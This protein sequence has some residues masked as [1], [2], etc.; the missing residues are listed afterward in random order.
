MFDEI[1]RH[2]R[3]LLVLSAKG[4]TGGHKRFVTG[5]QLMTIQSMYLFM[6]AVV[7][8]LQV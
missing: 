6:L 4:T 3:Y 8:D 2:H 5:V 7:Y 1:S